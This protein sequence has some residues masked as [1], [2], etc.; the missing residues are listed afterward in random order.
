MNMKVKKGIFWGAI[1]MPIVLGFPFLSG[2]SNALAAGF[3]GH[4]RGGM[5]MGPKGGGFGG[6]H[7]MMNA[8][9]HGGFSW[10]GTLVF[11]AIIIAV[12]YF[13]VKWL[14]GKSKES[15]MQ[16]FIDTSMMSSYRPTVNHNASVLDQWE[17]SIKTKRENE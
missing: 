11:L 6:G 12:G 17:Q 15:S 5:G 3:H 14:R 1:M 9:Q 2:G 8:P 7:Q 10:I 4:D 13:V 16:Q